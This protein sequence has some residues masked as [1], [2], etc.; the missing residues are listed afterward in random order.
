MLRVTFQPS[1]TKMNPVLDY[2][3]E[4]EE[5]NQS[6][7]LYLHELIM[8]QAEIKSKIRYKVPFYFRQSWFCYLNPVK[9]GIELNFV[10]ANEMSNANGLLDFRGRTQVA[11][12]IYQNIEAVNI[13]PL[14]ETI[15][16]ALLLDETVKY[17]SKRKPR[18]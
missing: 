10:R 3:Y 17:A 6:L 2:I 7:L 11:G 14:I 12:V 9:N 4:Q 18:K 5:P 16:E 8:E 15:Q 13:E 1:S